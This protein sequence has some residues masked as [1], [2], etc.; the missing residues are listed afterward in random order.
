MIEIVATE[1]QAH[2]NPDGIMLKET[3]VFTACIK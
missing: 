2:D 3:D 1:V